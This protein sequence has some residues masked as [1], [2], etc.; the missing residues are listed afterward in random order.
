MKMVSRDLWTVQPSFG[1]LC[2]HHTSDSS[3]GSVQG[4]RAHPRHPRAQ[5]AVLRG[6][7]SPPS[8]SPGTARHAQG[9]CRCAGTRAASNT[10]A[11][12]GPQG[13]SVAELTGIKTRQKQRKPLPKGLTLVVV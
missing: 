8:P 5:P 11:W 13:P 2:I 12:A 6:P 10:P 7:Q 4:R 9:P 3:G 1:R